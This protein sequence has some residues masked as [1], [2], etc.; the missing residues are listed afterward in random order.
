MKKEEIIKKFVLQQG[1]GAPIVRKGTC[2]NHIRDIEKLLKGAHI[3]INARSEEDVEIDLI[4]EKLSRATASSY[5]FNTP[6]GENGERAGPVG[7]TYRRYVSF[8][9][10]EKKK[11]S[12][13]IHYFLT[14]VIF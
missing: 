6:R 9:Y 1:E 14:T 4:M 13:V 2:A 12:S 7:T 3:T 5:K 10:I 8:I 11:K